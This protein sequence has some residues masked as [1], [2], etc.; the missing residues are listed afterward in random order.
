[1]SVNQTEQRDWSH[2]TEPEWVEVDGVQTAYR[3][4]GDGP[5]LLYLHGAGVTRA[6]LPFYERLSASFDVIVPEHPGFGDTPLPDWLRSVDDL[7][8]HY[9]A[10]LRAL[11]VES[12]HIVG[13]SLGGWV[14]A[15]LAITYPQRFAT[16]ALVCPMGLR[17][18]EAPMRDPFR[19]CAE[20]A[21]EL[22]LNGAAH[23][24]YLEFFQQ[25]GEFEDTIHAY[26]E[27]ITL[28]RLL[29]NPRYDTRLDR[30][31]ARVQVPTLIVGADED[32]LVPNA[33]IAR[34]A[35]LISNAS[36]ATV[37]GSA[38]ESTGHLLTIQ[39]PGRLAEVIVEHARR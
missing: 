26:S 28:A 31:L 15:S 39:Q 23:E 19:M 16:L 37:I 24:K 18:P 20:H 13:H 35:E 34:W 4:K 5:P 3:R 38:D 12:A 9:D 21:N 6:W 27:S 7:V 22:L 32:R 30:R 36:T 14:A 25:A 29:W 17:V 11:D 10:L 1:M 2:W 33:H 8:L